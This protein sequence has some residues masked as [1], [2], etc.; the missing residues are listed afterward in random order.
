MEEYKVIVCGGRGFGIDKAEHQYIQTCLTALFVGFANQTD[1]PQTWVP[2]DNLKIITGGAEGVD[3]AAID[4]AVVN[5]VNFEEVKADWKKYGKAAGPIRNQQMLDMS[6]KLVVAFPGGAGTADMI[7][8][9][10]K[11]GTLVI[12]FAYDNSLN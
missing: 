5:W 12:Q 3:S 10:K 1:D 2:P 6:P 8:R 4:W 11:K 7:Q 9:A